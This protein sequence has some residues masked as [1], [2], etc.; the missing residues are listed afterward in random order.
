MAEPQPWQLGVLVA[1]ASPHVAVQCLPGLAAKRQGPPAAALAGNQQNVQLMEPANVLLRPMLWAR[2][3]LILRPLPC[4]IQR[5][6]SACTFEEQW[7][8]KDRWKAAGK[9]S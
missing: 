8:G 7:T 4:Q 9:S 1:G 6:Q 3:E 2:E 5:A